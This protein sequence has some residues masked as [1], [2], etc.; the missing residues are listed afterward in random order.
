MTS[1]KKRKI[2]IGVIG[3]VTLLAV[4]ALVTYLA[5]TIFIPSWH[6]GKA[7]KLLA[8]GDLD[9]AIQEFE[10]ARW[11]KDAAFRNTDLR[12]KKG[13]ALI[14]AGDYSGAADVFYDSLGA[15]GVNKDALIL[16]AHVLLAHSK[17][18][19][20][21]TD[22]ASV[23]LGKAA[24]EIEGLAWPSRTIN[25]EEHRSAYLNFFESEDA[26]RFLSTFSLLSESGKAREAT[27]ILRRFTYGIA[28]KLR[29][30]Q[31]YEYVLPSY[32]ETQYLLG[33]LYLKNNQRSDAIRSFQAIAGYRDASEQ[34]AAILGFGKDGRFGGVEWYVVDFVNGYTTLISRTIVAKKAL[35]EGNTLPD[36]RDDFS[37][38]RYLE[39]DFLNTFSKQEQ[40]RIISVG[41]LPG[42]RA[43][44][45]P[46]GR[47]Y[48]PADIL[49]D[50]EWWL[51][52]D[53]Y[54]ERTTSTETDYVNGKTTERA[55]AISKWNPQWVSDGKVQDSVFRQRVGSESSL[56]DYSVSEA[57]TVRDVRPVIR[58]SD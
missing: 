54:T 52:P 25:F 11:Y 34:T 17:S 46:G 23:A 10:Q 7:E 21:L 32:R 14:D 39:S 40:S 29:E 2:V 15:G 13:N 16:R 50:G 45:D 18:E 56:R 33:S 31:S 27:Q 9:G 55:E 58:I 51:D 22:E 41:L 38:Q 44:R 43:G 8:S 20:G 37:L 42:D 36:S 30:D 47:E 26:G 3:V 24:D 4:T 19:A 5:Q 28:G 35:H 57:N 1:S 6:Y 49:Q 53:K 12:V 48:L